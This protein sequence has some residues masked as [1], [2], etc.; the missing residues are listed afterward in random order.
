MEVSEHWKLCSEF[1]IVQAGLIIAGYDP[2]DLQFC[3]DHVIRQQTIGYTAARTAL[4]HAVRSGSL[5][6]TYVGY[7]SV[8]EGFNYQKLID[9][10]TTTVSS[11]ELRDFLRARGSQCDFFESAASDRS[12]AWEPNHPQ[13]PRKLDVAVKAWTAVAGDRQALR[14]KSP[15]QALEKWLTEHAQELGLLKSDG[16]PNRS[17]IED[18]SKVA[19]W[20]PEGGAIPTPSAEP[21]TPAPANDERFGFTA[22]PRGDGRPRPRPAG[23]RE[24][25]SADLDDEIPF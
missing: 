2:E 13:F 11:A 24:S 17:G 18:I 12:T 3:E 6:T 7:E 9:P 22:A 10:Y 21:E 14:G 25:F 23:P 20:K 1:T 19:N 5:P 4:F 16:T 15:K 8:G